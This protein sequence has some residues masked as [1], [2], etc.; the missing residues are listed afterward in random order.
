MCRLGEVT[1]ADNDACTACSRNQ[2]S[3]N[4]SN[5]ACDDCPSNSI[6]PGDPLAYAILPDEGYWHSSPFDPQVLKCPIDGACAAY[7]SD[8]MAQLLL[9]LNGTNSTSVN[10]TCV[11]AAR[12]VCWGTCDACRA[13]LVLQHIGRCLRR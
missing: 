6:C 12:V 10:R 2:F 4:T 11:A 1:N 8:E 9:A 7:V 5:T 13:Q 3:A